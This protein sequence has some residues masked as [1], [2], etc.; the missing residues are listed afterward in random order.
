MFPFFNHIITIILVWI[1]EKEERKSWKFGLEILVDLFSHLIIWEMLL[2]G[3]ISFDQN[4]QTNL[5]EIF[6]F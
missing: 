4:N 2:A 6:S 3:L 5:K 1:L